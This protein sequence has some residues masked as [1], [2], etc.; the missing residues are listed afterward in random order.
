MK[1]KELSTVAFLSDND[2]LSYTID[3][4]LCSKDPEP[5]PDPGPDPKL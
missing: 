3:N 5:E 4:I 1:I 2:F